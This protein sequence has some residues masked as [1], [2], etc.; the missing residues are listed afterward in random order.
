M[1]KLRSQWS[2]A[3][4]KRPTLFDDEPAPVALPAVP[5][6][7]IIGGGLTGLSAAYHLSK[8]G[9][10]PV[11]FEAGLVGDGASGRTGGIVLEGTAAG[12]L[13]QVDTC[14]PELMRLVDEEEI[15]CDLAL[16][17]CWEIEHPRDTRAAMLPWSDDGRIVSI[18][19]TV[20]G[21]TVQPMAL[22]IG[23]AR[24]AMRM[25]AVIREQSPV[26]RINL[27]P[28]LSL[29]TGGN[30]ITPAHLVIATNAWINA[31]LP[32]TPLLHSSLTF[33]CA[34]EP[35]DSSVLTT[36]G[37]E[38]GMPFYTS[39]L[40][41]LW[42]RPMRDGRMIFGAGLVYGKPGVLERTD[43]AEGDS[44]SVLERLEKRV[45][46]LHPALRAVRFDAAWA[47]PIAFTDHSIP[48]LGLHPR[49]PRVL[50]AGGYAGHGV[51]LSVRAGEL[52]ARAIESNS[53]LPSWG[54]LARRNRAA[55]NS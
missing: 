14:V 6:V 39:D 16:P 47:G 45:R 20:A 50:V 24:A 46:G 10:R 21:G 17:G 38:K 34:T 22:L 13:D 27:E 5:D 41:Y 51:A 9:L 44:R 30:R 7:A 4:W 40:P 53:P 36:I 19:R 31:T 42:G 52:L 3:P 48:L 54:S 1:M 11:L 37:L 15:D 43:V 2:T 49:Q 12:I 18:E 32:E 55:R 26:A 33:A 8:I 23:I 28:E 35:L 29:E 25:G